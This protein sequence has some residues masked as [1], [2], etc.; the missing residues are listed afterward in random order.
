MAIEKI[1]DIKIQGNA[2]VAVGTLKQQLKAAKSEV[3]ALSDEFG[4]TSTQ[5]IRAAEKAA[6]LSHEIANANKL[7]KSFNPSTTL[8]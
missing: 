4:I 6:E 7:V 5:A 1:I 8:N 3:I 2:E